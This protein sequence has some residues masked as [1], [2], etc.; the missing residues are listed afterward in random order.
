MHNISVFREGI[1][2]RKIKNVSFAVGK[3]GCRPCDGQLS[4]HIVQKYEVR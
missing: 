2:D 3:S 1:L 4:R